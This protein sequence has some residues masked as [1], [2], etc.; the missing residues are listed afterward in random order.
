M[1]FSCGRNESRVVV[2]VVWTGNPMPSQP[3]KNVC[4]LVPM[5]EVWTGSVVSTHS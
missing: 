1:A 4:S 5:A 3:R 2:F